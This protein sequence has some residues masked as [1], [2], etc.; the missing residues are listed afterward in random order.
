MSLHEEAQKL[1]EELNSVKDE[2]IDLNFQYSQK[3]AESKNMRKEIEQKDEVI[4]KLIRKVKILNLDKKNSNNKFENLKTENN[5]RILRNSLRMADC[6]RIQNAT[7]MND[8][9]VKGD[10]LERK[11]NTLVEHIKVN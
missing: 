3:V 2:L 1:R 8:A 5:I 9:K 11:Y 7:K 4:N 10:N 6:E